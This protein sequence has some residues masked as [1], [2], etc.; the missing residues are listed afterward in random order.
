MQAETQTWELQDRVYYDREWKQE[1][2]ESKS[3]Q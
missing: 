2:S 1:I 3:S